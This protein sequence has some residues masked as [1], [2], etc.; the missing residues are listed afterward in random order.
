MRLRICL[1]VACSRSAKAYVPRG[2][3]AQQMAATCEN[4]AGHLLAGCLQGTEIVRR[5]RQDTIR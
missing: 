5:R 3:S 4:M 1:P 2:T